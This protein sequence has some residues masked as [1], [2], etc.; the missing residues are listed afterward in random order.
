MAKINPQST[1]HTGE[2]VEQGKYCSIAGG[3]AT[4]TDTFSEN[5]ELIY[6]KIQ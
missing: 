2:N 1:V 3:S 5:L 6:L 4:C